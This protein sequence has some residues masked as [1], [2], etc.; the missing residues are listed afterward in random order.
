MTPD[1]SKLGDRFKLGIIGSRSRVS[2][3]DRIMV[4]DIV[5]E[6]IKKFGIENI[7]I[8]S[9]GCPTGADHFAEEAAKH[10]GVSL[11]IHYPQAFPKST[12]Y[13]TIRDRYYARNRT[14]VEES[15]ILFGLVSADRKG[16]TEYTFK[17]AVKHNVKS[18]AVIKDGSRISLLG[19]D[20]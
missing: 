14:I 11:T 7:Q 18:Y 5:F 19:D 1:Q 20:E 15:D 16:G 4:F 6:H 2:A 13:N 17:H 10:F 12:S 8:V 9:G 3:R